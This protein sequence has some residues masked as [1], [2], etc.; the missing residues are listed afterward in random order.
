MLLTSQPG[1]REGKAHDEPDQESTCCEEPTEEP[2]DDRS[3]DGASA[4]KNAGWGNEDAASNSS[5]E[6]ETDDCEAT[7]LLDIRG[8]PFER[9]L[10]VAA[11]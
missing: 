7:Y 6:D 11:I 8:H 5:V 4:L 1:S 2:E 10:C 3:T 9:L